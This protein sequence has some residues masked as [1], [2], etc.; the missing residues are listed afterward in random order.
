MDLQTRMKHI[1]TILNGV[2]YEMTSAEIARRYVGQYTSSDVL[3]TGSILNVMTHL[4][5]VKKI[6]FWAGKSERYRFK[7]TGNNLITL[8]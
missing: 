3:T 7:R 8:V 5:L 6:S 4:G 1:V 2:D